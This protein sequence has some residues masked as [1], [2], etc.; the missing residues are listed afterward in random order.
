MY[1]NKAATVLAVAE[2]ARRE[3]HSEDAFTC[4]H[5]QFPIF[6]NL[7]GVWDLV[8][9]EWRPT[10]TCWQSPTGEHEP[11]RQWAYTNG[12]SGSQG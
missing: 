9:V 12:T 1:T 4:Q 5:C 7:E 3:R 8:Y 2:Q 11:T 6:Q 10:T